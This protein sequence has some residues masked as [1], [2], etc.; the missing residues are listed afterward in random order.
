[1]TPSL[2]PSQSPTIPT[3]QPTAAETPT[4]APTAPTTR[5]SSRPTAT[6]A[7]AVATTSP[8]AEDSGGGGV[9][10]AIVVVVVLLGLGGAV[11]WKRDAIRAKFG[12]RAATTDAARGAVEMRMNPMTQGS[13]APAAATVEVHHEANSGGGGAR[14]HRALPALPARPKP[15]PATSVQ[16][17]R[18]LFDYTAQHRDELSFTAG[19]VITITSADSH[20]ES[21]NK[22]WLHGSLP[23]G[24]TGVFP[25]N[26]V[27]MV[28]SGTRA[29]PGA[30]EEEAADTSA[31]V[32]GKEIGRALFDYQG[33]HEDELT[34]SAGSVITISPVQSHGQGPDW[35]HGSLPGG[36]DGIFPASYVQLDVAAAANQGAIVPE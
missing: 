23:N 7:K 21:G 30:A 1:M 19:D 5:P 33:Q 26:Y 29:P 18:A 14:Q 27:E 3:K 36:E 17:A 32:A 25:A 10:G 16:T 12:R 2:L 34:F 20:A 24:R 6:I 28:A 13:G 11:Y 8:T 15:A 31:S 4:E 35:L 22:D 9:A